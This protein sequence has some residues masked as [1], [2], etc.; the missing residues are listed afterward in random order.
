MVL[1]LAETLDFRGSKGEGGRECLGWR[2]ELYFRASGD[3]GA[4]V[5]GQRG[6]AR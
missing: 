2:T 4:G 1:E 6:V 5:E 3:S